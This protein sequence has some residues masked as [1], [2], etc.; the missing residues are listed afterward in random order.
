M[1]SINTHIRFYPA[2]KLKDRFDTSNHHSKTSSSIVCHSKINTL[3]HNEYFLVHAV[4]RGENEGLAIDNLTSKLDKI[5]HHHL[6]SLSYYS[7]EL[8]LDEKLRRRWDLWF[9]YEPFR[10]TLD[11]YIVKKRESELKLPDS[12]LSHVIVNL[13]SLF[14]YLHHFNVKYKP[15]HPKNFLAISEETI[16][17]DALDLGN[18][19]FIHPEGLETPSYMKAPEEVTGHK[20]DAEKAAVY[21]LGIIFMSIVLLK[22][23]SQLNTNPKTLKDEI[24]GQTKKVPKFI[25]ELLKK[26][27]NVDPAQRLNFEELYKYAKANNDTSR[28]MNGG[29]GAKI[30]KG[31]KFSDDI[32]EEK[33]EFK[34]FGALKMVP[35]SNSAKDLMKGKST[36]TKVG[37]SHFRRDSMSSTTKHHHHQHKPI[38]MET[39]K[40]KEPLRIDFEKLNPRVK[41]VHKFIPGTKSLLVVPLVNTK[42]VFVEVIELFNTF[43]IPKYH[44]SVYAENSRLYM[45]GGRPGNGQFSNCYYYV[46]GFES[47]I[48]ME[49]FEEK[50]RL[51]P[52]VCNVKDL[53]YVM[54][55]STVAGKGNLNSCEICN[56]VDNTWSSMASMK[57]RCA[58]ALFCNY[59]NEFIY[60]IGGVNEAGKILTS[61]ERYSIKA[62]RWQE[63]ANLGVEKMIPAKNQFG[64]QINSSEIFVFGGVNKDGEAINQTFVLGCEASYR[65]EEVIRSLDKHCPRT[66]RLD[67]CVQNQVVV[68]G[69]EIIFFSQSGEGYNKVSSFDGES[70]KELKKLTDSG[71]GC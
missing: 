35:K 47:L 69:K 6:Y 19:N 55:G 27:L 31:I 57:N 52:G 7:Y 43:M 30:T 29:S 15:I 37:K 44:T 25:L 62:N 36:E 1:K 60:R 2:D 48:E 54:G 34:V 53:I 68:V 23:P 14:T 21:H 17:F 38:E 18:Y 42:T 8:N 26:M 65:D 20:I 63:L 10:Y 4:T 70:W 3:D 46:D 58:E 56:T 11:E 39:L 64:V 59:Q 66:F 67:D 9:L 49:S 12:E 32:T 51:N 61:I 16:K 13:I 5:S 24:A 41:S 71:A 33:K 50:V 45:I 28:T 22:E 40:V